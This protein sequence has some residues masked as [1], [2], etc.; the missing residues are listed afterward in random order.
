MKKFFS[1]K[2]RLKTPHFYFMDQMYGIKALFEQKFRNFD[3]PVIL[4]SDQEVISDFAIFGHFS[5]IFEWKVL[6]FYS[7]WLIKSSIHRKLIVSS[8][9]CLNSCFVMNVMAQKYQNEQVYG[10]DTKNRGLRSQL[11]ELC[12]F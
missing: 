4:V 8:T 10:H 3:R 6:K 1:E 9:K 11:Y 5:R 2:S 12:H 7:S